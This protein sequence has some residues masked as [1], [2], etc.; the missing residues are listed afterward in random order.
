MDLNKLSMGDKVV[1]GAGIALVINLVF[2]PWHKVDLG[3]LKVTRTGIESPNAIWGILAML[4]ALAM[5]AV[6]VVG[7]LTTAKLPEIGMPWEQAE[8][9]AGG[10][11]AALLVLKLVLETDALGFGAF[12]GIILAGVVVYGAIVMRKE[13]GPTASGTGPG[14]TV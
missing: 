4:V 3:I 14:S 9:I 10:A 8:L 11:V 6:V 7:R 13:S 5:V 2:L 1:A 12:L